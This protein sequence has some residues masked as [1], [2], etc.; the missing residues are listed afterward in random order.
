M[1]L[2]H[3]LDF[4]TGLVFSSPTSVTRIILLF[5][6]LIDG[7]RIFKE[8]TGI[9]SHAFEGF[10]RGCI[11][12]ELELVNFIWIISKLFFRSAGFTHLL[13]MFSRFYPLF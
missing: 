8:P 13:R 11:L 6:C 5:G 9:V 10:S 2:F 12:L 3:L 1:K 7:S 4:T